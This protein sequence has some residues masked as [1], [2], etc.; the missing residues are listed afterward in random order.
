MK[1]KTLTVNGVSYTVADPDSVSYTAQDLTSQQKAQARENIG[2]AD[3]DEMADL[4]R[5]YDGV[6]HETAGSA[7]RKQIND[8]Y[9]ELSNLSQGFDASIGNIETALDSILAIQNQ[10]I[11]GDA[12]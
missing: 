9:N 1:M 6:I 5:D 7:V 3:V 2:A 12:S 10:L 11:G 4:R 8:V